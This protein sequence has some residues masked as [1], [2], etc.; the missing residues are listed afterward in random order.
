MRHLTKIFVTVLFPVLLS[1]PAASILLPVTPPEIDNQ[2]LAPPEPTPSRLLQPSFYKE[3]LHYLKTANPVRPL[4]VKL[5]AGIDYHVLGESPN[6]SVV[7]LGRDG[8]LFRREL[9]DAFCD[10]TH[11]EAVENLVRFV[12]EI[13][14][15]GAQV[16]YTLAPP[17]FALYPEYLRN[18]QRELI[19]C[20]MRGSDLLRQELASRRDDRYI[21]AW[22]L[23]GQLKAGGS[24]THFRTDTHFNYVGSIPWMREIISRIGSVNWEEEAVV[25]EGRV[26]FEGNLGA[27]IVPG[28]T[29][30]VEKVVIDRGLPRTPA[31]QLHERRSATTTAT[32][33]YIAR[34]T[35]LPAIDDKALAIG[36]SYLILPEPSLAQYF[37][38][39]TFTDW[40]AP[41]S[42]QHFLRE[43][44]T[45]DVVLIELAAE[46]IYRYFS[47]GSLLSRYRSL[48]ETV[49]GGSR[50]H[51]GQG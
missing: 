39:I 34:G 9:F 24:L 20:G 38:N 44:V 32:E 6:P 47:D 13:S 14:L 37:T 17:K 25:D 51:L 43:A 21:D 33:T 28:L 36:D 48:Q 10:Q 12:D 46:S 35:S 31:V 29:E 45:A 27:L 40:R 41:R 7:L 18:D 26:R 2:G 4:L 42:L 16:L 30:L 22:E 50:D 49:E 1:L 15:R 8:W 3:T 23:F 5:G 11:S 19:E